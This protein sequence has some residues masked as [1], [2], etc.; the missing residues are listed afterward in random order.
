VVLRYF[1][2]IVLDPEISHTRFRVWNEKGDWLPSGNEHNSIGWQ[3]WHTNIHVPIAIWA[4]TPI[5]I[6]GRDGGSSQHRDRANDPETVIFK[7]P[8]QHAHCDD[9]RQHFERHGV[10]VIREAESPDE[11]GRRSEG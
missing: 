6:D 11:V 7:E 5:G 3:L 8:E 4:T 1:Q 10:P 9:A 2:I